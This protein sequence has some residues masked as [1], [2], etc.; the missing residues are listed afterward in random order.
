MPC[1]SYTARLAVI[2]DKLEPWFMSVVQVRLAIAAKLHFCNVIT[3]VVLEVNLY[4]EKGG[5]LRVLVECSCF[6]FLGVFLPLALTW[7]NERQARRD[8]VSQ[9]GNIPAAQIGSY[10]QKYH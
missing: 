1:S 4:L 6:A 8:Y 2:Q 5:W 7:R 10:W 9:F 3:F